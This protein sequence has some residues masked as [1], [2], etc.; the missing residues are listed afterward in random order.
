MTEAMLINGERVPSVTGEWFDVVDPATEE[1]V[2]Q[3]PMANEDDAR[4]AIAAANTAF[5]SWRTATAHERAG[6]CT[7]WPAKFAPAPMIWPRS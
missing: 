1:V 3:A 2:G 5:R 7:K 6:C 4:R